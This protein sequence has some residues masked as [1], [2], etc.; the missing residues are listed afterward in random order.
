MPSKQTLYQQDL[1]DWLKEHREIVKTD[2]SQR[3]HAILSDPPYFLGSINKRFSKNNSAPAQYGK[4]GSFNRLSKG[5]MGKTWDGFESPQ[6]FQAWVTEWGSMLLDVVYPGAMGMFF[7]GT[8][9]YHRLAS[10]LE[11]AGWEIVDCMMY[12][13]GSGFPKA[14]DLGKGYKTRLKPAYEPVVIARAPRT[15]TYRD[16]FSEYG[17]GG[18]NIDGCRIETDDILIAGGN[19][20]KSVA[21]SRKNAALGMFQPG[22]SNT[23]KQNENGRYPSHLIL[24]EEAAEQLDE[25]SG[26]LKAGGNL[27]GDEPSSV[28]SG[29]V[30]RFFY[31]TKSPRWEREAGLENFNL[32]TIDDGRKKS[33]D[34]AYQRGETERRNTHPTVKPVK[35]NEYLARLILPPQSMSPRRILVPFAGS[36]SE[37]I[38]CHFAGWDE[39]VGI[40]REEEYCQINEARRKWWSGFSSYAEAEKVY[41]QESKETKSEIKSSDKP[42]QLSMF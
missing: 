3:F 19:L 1:F 11:D 15:G 24:D 29:G 27:T 13:F 14:H 41:K 39:I 10:G 18:F 32:D 42:Q 12:L 17:T 21:D 40:E 16:Q 4:D 6:H 9:T 38:G 35:L 30:S 7:G 20:V 25:Q 33:I 26:E 5:F 37:M 8:R 28:M 22:T 36:G 2:G 34:N 23:Y 31:T